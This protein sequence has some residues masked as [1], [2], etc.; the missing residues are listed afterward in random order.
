MSYE[1]IWFKRDL[2]WED[3]AALA[4]AARR[5]PV[6]C[7]YIVEP[8]LW[9]QADMAMGHFG[10][11]S[12]SLID[13]DVE[14]RKQGGGLEV[15]TGEVI[16]ILD[17]VWQHH[18]FTGLHSHEETGNQWTYDR[19]RRVGRWCRDHHIPWHEYPQFGVVRRLK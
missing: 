6:R 18:P 7:I 15:F 4:H 10:F 11:I 3:H 12:E 9:Q 5:G 1:L 13:L 17:K 14:L 19:D 2:R 8:G 16:E